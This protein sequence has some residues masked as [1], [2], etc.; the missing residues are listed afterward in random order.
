VFIAEPNLNA[1]DDNFFNDKVSSIVV[2]REVVI[3]S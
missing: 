3:F 2:L 1:N